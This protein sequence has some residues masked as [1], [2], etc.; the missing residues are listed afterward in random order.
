MKIDSL[1]SVKAKNALNKTTF[2]MVKNTEK[3]TSGLQIN[4]S[5]DNAAG[6]AISEKMRS[7]IRGLTQSQDNTNDGISL[8]NVGEGALNEVH[9]ILQRIREMAVQSANGT[10]MDETDREALQSELERLTVEVDRI[11]GSTEFNGIKLFQNEGYESEYE[12]T[13]YYSQFTS[14][15]DDMYSSTKYLNQEIALTDLLAQDNAGKTNIIYSETIFEFETEQTPEGPNSFTVDEKAYADVLKAEIVPNIVS[16][17]TTNYPAFSYLN[18]TNIGI[19]L[20]LYSDSSSSTL[21]YVAAAAG[22]SFKQYQLAVNI[23]RADLTTESGR[24]A[25][26][27]TIAH[28]MIHA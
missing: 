10:Y 17:I 2:R 13:G 7:I 24:S 19:G 5:A 15:F 14:L 26:E 16:K 6:L 12:L 22:G 1:S 20:K 11:A 23:G 3:L 4:R 18:G 21:A 8:V 25:L 28:E 27:R 9:S